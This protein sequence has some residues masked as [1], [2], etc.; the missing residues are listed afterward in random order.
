MRVFDGKKTGE[1]GALFQPRFT[2]WHL[3]KGDIEKNAMQAGFFDELQKIAGVDIHQRAAEI[4]GAVAKDLKIS[5][6]KPFLT[7]SMALGLNVPGKADYDYGVPI[8]SKREYRRVMRHLDKS[9]NW[10][11]SNYNKGNSDYMVYQGKI[12]K[13]PVDVALLYGAKGE[14]QRYAIEAANKALTPEARERII[15]KKKLVK[16]PF[17]P[18]FIE[19]RV[20]RGIDAR[21]GLPRF[22]K[23]TLNWL[24]AKE[25]TAL[26]PKQLGRSDVFGHRTHNLAP[27]IESG[28]LLSAVQA[29]R[30]GGLKDYETGT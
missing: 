1:P 8:G 6:N 25:K 10:K 2:E 23:N 7:G 29:A 17:V 13:D 16:S 28:R 14:F 3:D 19:R 22:T 9:P 21:L 5:A 18:K 15:A 24:H 4:Q 12:G 20:K 26:D 30:E 11:P 27:I